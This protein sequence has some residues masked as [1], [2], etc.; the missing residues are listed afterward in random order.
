[1]LWGIWLR[2]LQEEKINENEKDSQ[3]KKCGNL[4]P[5]E[6]LSFFLIDYFGYNMLM[7]KDLILYVAWNWSTSLWWWCWWWWWV[8][9]LEVLKPI[10][11][12]SLGLSQAE[13]QNN[14]VE[15]EASLKP[16]WVLA[17]TKN[18]FYIFHCFLS[19]QLKLSLELG[20]MNV[21][22]YTLHLNV[23]ITD[24]GFKYI[25]LKKILKN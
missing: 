14:L 15:I 16:S 22:F 12:F 17:S 5:R 1:M 6:P 3:F 10:L 8:G 20:P 25:K 4:F 2:D 11:L 24:S 21:I 7:Y 19:L 23:W 13:Q 18:K 9:R